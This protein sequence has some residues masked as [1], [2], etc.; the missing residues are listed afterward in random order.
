MRRTLMR[1]RP[2]KGD[3][4]DVGVTPNYP[5]KGYRSIDILSVT[6]HTKI[7]VPELA[8]AANTLTKP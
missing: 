1:F 4:Y 2:M 8:S 3:A 5:V 7:S 6:N